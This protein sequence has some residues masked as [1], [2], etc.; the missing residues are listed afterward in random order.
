MR[1]TH[2]Y[3]VLDISE[4][5]WAEIAAKLRAADYAHCFSRDGKEIDM[6]GIAVRAEEGVQH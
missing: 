3:V 1:Q 2:T 6:T 5:A 4:S